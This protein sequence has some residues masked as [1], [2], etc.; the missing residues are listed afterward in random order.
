QLFCNVCLSECKVCFT[1]DLKCKYMKS[2][3]LF[4]SAYK[5]VGW[6]LFAT[7][8]LV[9]AILLISGHDLD[10][11]F[12]TDVFAVADAE[13]FAPKAFFVVVKYA[14]LDELLLLMMLVGGILAGFSRHRHEDEMISRIRYESLVWAVYF[15]F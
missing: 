7:S 10:A 9:A 13:L 5:V 2:N 4:P 1:F 3:F 11:I 6:V 8:L 15:N 14:I 12:V